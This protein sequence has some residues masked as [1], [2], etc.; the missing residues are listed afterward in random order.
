MQA[1]FAWESLSRTLEH[2][3][4]VREYLDKILHLRL[5]KDHV[6][7]VYHFFCLLAFSYPIKLVLALSSPV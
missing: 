4:I 1:N 3:V 5:N 7:L 2:S 6:R